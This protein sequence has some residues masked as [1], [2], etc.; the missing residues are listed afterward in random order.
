M[1]DDALRLLGLV[2]GATQYERPSRADDTPLDIVRMRALPLTVDKLSTLQELL[3]VDQ[4]QG[5]IRLTFRQ[6]SAGFRWQMTDDVTWRMPY[7][8]DGLAPHQGQEN[9]D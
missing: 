2:V 4:M 7:M 9:N 3:F 5:R 1:F 8:T 6:V